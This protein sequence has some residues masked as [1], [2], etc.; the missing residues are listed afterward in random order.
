MI[1]RQTVHTKPCIISHDGVIK[2]K[3]FLRYWP[4]VRGLHRSPANSPHK[5]QWCGTLMF[6]LICA[7]TNAW[8]NN[9]EAGDLWRLR[10]HYDVTLM[11][12]HNFSS[13][14]I[15]VMPLKITSQITLNSDVICLTF[16]SLASRYYRITTC[17]NRGFG[18]RMYSLPWICNVHNPVP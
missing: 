18:P 9:R 17:L 4:F 15:S 14:N 5:G 11:M 8:V 13:C 16:C 3:R 7:W 2:W 1:W 12:K 10:A 6:I